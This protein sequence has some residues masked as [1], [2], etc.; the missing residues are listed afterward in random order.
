MYS[1]N[2]SVKNLFTKRLE[3]SRS[4]YL[5]NISNTSLHFFRNLSNKS[6]VSNQFFNK[7]IFSVRQLDI[8]SKI[9]P[10]KIF[11]NNSNIAEQLENKRNQ[12]I[13]ELDVKKKIKLNPEEE[14]KQIIPDRVGKKNI[15]KLS[16]LLNEKVLKNRLSNILDQIDKIKKEKEN[17]KNKINESLKKIESNEVCIDI[18]KAENDKKTNLLKEYD[19]NMKNVKKESLEE[20]KSKRFNLISLLQREFEKNQ[21]LMNEFLSDIQ[22]N[23]ENIQNFEKEQLDLKKKLL[24]LKSKYKDIKKDLIQH[25]HYLLFEGIETRKDGLTWIIRAI[26]DLDEDVNMSFIPNF[27]D[28]KAIEYLFLISNKLNYISNI[29]K[30][31]NNTLKENS[32]NIPC[33][34]LKITLF[35]T[36]SYKDNIINLKKKLK[37]I[38][39]EKS[40]VINYFPDYDGL[41]ITKYN[42]LINI[43]KKNKKEKK[44]KSSEINHEKIEENFKK[45]ENLKQLKFKILNEIDILKKKEVKRITREFLENDYERRFN[46]PIKIVLSALVGEYNLDKEYEKQKNYKNEYIKNIK[47][48]NFY[49]LNEKNKNKK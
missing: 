11:E 27:L 17:I 8:N 18:I 26:W 2:Y 37:K 46:V 34:K 32:K 42:S 9:I 14:E 38:K 25:Y 19:N 31:M 6:T 24:K 30:S 35:K 7:E 12:Y 16:I 45:Y 29:E 40:N 49:R 43:I 1:G 44:S 20:F 36:N 23:K 28:E 3:R 47:D 15:H 48:C 13:N 5:P 4:F 10:I 39:N 33:K 21:V 22:L 41:K